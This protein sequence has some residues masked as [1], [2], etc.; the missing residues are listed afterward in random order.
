[1]VLIYYLYS[2]K[3]KI[4]NLKKCTRCEIEKLEID[5]YKKPNSNQLLPHCKSCHKNSVTKSFKKK[6]DNAVKKR[7]RQLSYY[8]NK[9]AKNTPVTTDEDAEIWKDLRNYEGIYQVSINGEIRRWK[10]YLNKWVLLNPYSDK[11]GYLK[12]T[13]VNN[14]NENKR[15]LHRIIAEEFIK[16]ELNKNEVNHIDGDKKNNCVENLEWCNRSENMIHAHKLGLR[17]GITK[18]TKYGKISKGNRP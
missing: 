16:K 14:Y 12:V 5:F 2:Y 10:K 9:I 7:E 4:M 13:L 1:M 11:N 15:L 6:S 17:N 18:R 3:N 8:H